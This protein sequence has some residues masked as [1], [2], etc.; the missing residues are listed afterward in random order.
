MHDLEALLKQTEGKGINIYTH[1]EML[2]AHAYPGLRKYAHLAG[3]YGNAW[4]L[5]KVYSM[6][7][8]FIFCALF[9]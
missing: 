8:L 4:Q 5:Q 2:P 3:H 1:G 7:L 6:F 9:G